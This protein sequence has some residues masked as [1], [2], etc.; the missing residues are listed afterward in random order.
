MNND[1]QELQK[2][3]DELKK[4]VADLDKINK[5]KK[6][7]EKLKED[8]KTLEAGGVLSTPL[9]DLVKL[10]QPWQTNQK[11]CTYHEY[12]MLSP[13]TCIHC[14][15]NQ[16]NNWRNPLIGTGP[17]TQPYTPNNPWYTITSLSA[18]DGGIIG[19]LGAT[20]Q[21]IQGLVGQVSTTGLKY[22]TN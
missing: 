22:G 19:G 14:G 7:I 10:M 13:N 6:E 8:V 9:T 21:G 20:T 2:Q 3:V 4:K 1:V 15:Y 5:L 18:S 16:Y 11:I 17:F 12:N